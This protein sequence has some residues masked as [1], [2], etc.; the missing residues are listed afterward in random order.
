[1]A[2]LTW[3]EVG[4]RIYQTGVDHGVLYL[5]DGTVVPW[6]GLVSIEE[7]PDLEQK[8]FYLDGIKF[9]ESITPNDF[10]G[11]LTAFTYPEEFDTVN[12]IAHVSPGLSYYDQPPKSF[13][14]SYRTKIGNDVEGEDYGYKIH[15]LY[16][17]MAAPD[18]YSYG[19]MSDSSVQPITFAWT[20]SGTPQKIDKSRPTVHVSIDSRITPPEI[21]AIIESKLYGT[22]NNPPSLPIITEIGEYFG[23]RGAL[24]IIDFQDG[25]WMAI[26][27][28]DTFINFV[29]DPNNTNF[30]IDG[31]DATYLDVDTY[32]V[33]STDVGL[34]D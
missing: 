32:N 17:I 7:S 34:E 30:R 2:V 1:M 28:S 22:E 31:V 33:S 12:G 24:L 5:Q 29:D 11:K 13:N 26:D 21:M 4:D 8:S 27:E 9:L 20:L 3:D 14:L 19:S 16:N 15:I 18:S 6:N 10:Q 23:Y 25:T